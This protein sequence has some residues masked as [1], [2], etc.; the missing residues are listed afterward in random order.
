M[1]GL[2]KQRR[3]QIVGLAVVALIG[4]TVLVGYAMR[5]GINFFRAPSQIAADPPGPSEVFRIGGLVEVGTLVR[6]QGEVIRFNV[7]DG[8][9]SI[10]VTYSGIL[11]DLFGENQGMVGTGSYINGIFEATEILAKHDET[12]MPKEVID[13]LKEQG[14]YKEGTTPG[15]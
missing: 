3:V 8:G 9:A 11:P 10:P 7:T 14:V 15:S 13:A 4:A 6:G 1:K 2:K 5:D 12:Y